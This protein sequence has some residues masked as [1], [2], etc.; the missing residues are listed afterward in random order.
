M[1]IRNFETYSGSFT[2]QGLFNGATLRPSNL[3]GRGVFKWSLSQDGYF[4]EGLNS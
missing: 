3:A 1:K 2:I 4:F